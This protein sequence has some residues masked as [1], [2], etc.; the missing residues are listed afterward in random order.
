MQR[1]MDKD[2]DFEYN[3]KEFYYIRLNLKT[4]E[5]GGKIEIAMP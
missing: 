2:N 4:L 1:D 3:D 5:L